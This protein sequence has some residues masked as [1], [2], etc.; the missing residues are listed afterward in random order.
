MC[1]ERDSD[2]KELALIV[3]VTVRTRARSCRP[4]TTRRREN[5]I[6][7]IPLGRVA[8]KCK[9]RSLLLWIDSYI[10]IYI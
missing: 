6:V 7:I 10:L 1:V 4:C 3:V 9:K 2:I 8:D 5:F